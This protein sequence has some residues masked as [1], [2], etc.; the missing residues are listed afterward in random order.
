[1][2]KTVD[3]IHGSVDR[4]NDKKLFGV[5]MI[6]RVHLLAEEA[7]LRQRFP[8]TRHQKLLHAAVIFRDDVSAVGFGLRQ[9]F[10]RLQNESGSFPLCRDDAVKN[11]LIVIDAV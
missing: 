4:I 5:Q 6:L 1:V 10:M 3:K 9:Y 11:G 8:K 2:V 7:G